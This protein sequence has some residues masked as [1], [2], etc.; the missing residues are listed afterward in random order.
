MS[1]NLAQSVIFTS[2]HL[3]GFT[4]SVFESFGVPYEDA[5]L[6][7]DVLAYSDEHGIDS[8]GIARLKTYFDLL[9]AGRV[10]P[11]PTIRIVREKGGVATIDG[12]NGLGLVVGPQCMEIAMQKAAIA[13]SGWVSVCNTNH[14]GA[15]GYYPVMALRQDLIGISMTNT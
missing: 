14:F 8:H 9:K 10:N 11:K 7:A 12:D 15:G 1:Q 3:R 5:V 6:A 2:T 13:G 4:T